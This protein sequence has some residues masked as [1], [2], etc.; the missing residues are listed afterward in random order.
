LGEALKADH[1]F[2]ADSKAIQNLIEIMAEY[3]SVTRRSYLQF[4]TGSPKLPI[5]G[6]S[7]VD[8][9]KTYVNTLYRFPWSQPTAHRRTEASRV[10]SDGRRLPSK[11]DD[12]RQLLEA[13]RLLLQ[14]GYETEAAGSHVGRNRKFPPFV[15]STDAPPLDRY[16]QDIDFQPSIHLYSP[17]NALDS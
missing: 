1:G 9:I 8:Q 5:G 15:A 2:T 11:C 16:S 14:G 7:S 6:M 4:I 12:L 13:S 3:D 10:A 17:P